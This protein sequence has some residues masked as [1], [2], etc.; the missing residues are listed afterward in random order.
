[1]AWI[2]LVLCVRNESFQSVGAYPVQVRGWKRWVLRRV[3][4]QLQP[5]A[6]MPGQEG[7]IQLRGVGIAVGGQIGTQHRR[8]VGHVVRGALR[9]TLGQHGRRKAGKPLGKLIKQPQDSKNGAPTIDFSKE[10]EKAKAG[11][12]KLFGK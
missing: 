12:K 3:G 5:A 6:E 2:S 9:C 11:L 8:L 1:M 7:D 4:H 10:E